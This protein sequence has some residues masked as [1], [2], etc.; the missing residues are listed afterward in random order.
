MIQK[1]EPHECT[2]KYCLPDLS[3]VPKW[4]SMCCIALILIFDFGKTCFENTP[5]NIHITSRQ[6]LRHSDNRFFFVF[7]NRPTTCKTCMNHVKP[8]RLQR[9]ANVKPM[10]TRV[11]PLNT[12][13]HKVCKIK[14]VKSKAKIILP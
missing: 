2:K 10:S 8:I 4:L 7:V 9:T 3:C 14:V 11:N 1:H 12:Y 6:Q 13:S 5:D